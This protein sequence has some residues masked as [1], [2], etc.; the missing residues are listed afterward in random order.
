VRPQTK[1]CSK[2]CA[3][4]NFHYRH[5]NK[6]PRIGRTCPM[7]D[8]GIDS[9]RHPNAVYCS[10]PCRQA[11]RI[12]VSYGMTCAE[13]RR[14]REAQGGACAICAAAANDLWTNRH[15]V[16]DGFHIDHDHATGKVRG[17]LC[18]SCNLM[19]GYAKDDPHVLERA[20]AY[21]AAHQLA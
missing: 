14:L 19:L 6:K 12:V 15:T 2:N 13:Y 8:A 18:P 7:C 5:Y 9:S 3:S 17:I 1:F 10:V 4:L 21:L 11:A 20:A 16:R